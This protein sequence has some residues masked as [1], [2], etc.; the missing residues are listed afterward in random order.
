M[1]REQLTAIA[2]TILLLMIPILIAGSAP[3]DFP[4]WDRLPGW[5]LQKGF[6]TTEAV[7][8]GAASWN[9]RQW[10]EWLA[11]QAGLDG[12]SNSTIEVYTYLGKRVDIL[13]PF[14]A[15]EVGW[16]HHWKE[17]PSQAKQYSMQTNRPG[18]VILLSNGSIGEAE[19]IASCLSECERNG[20]RMYVQRVP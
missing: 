9:E 17:D 19:S 10:S 14:E 15:I 11:K 18:A 6:D 20:L 13:T 2:A 16:A 8:N 5:S 12:E 4:Q 1:R 3:Q 7:A